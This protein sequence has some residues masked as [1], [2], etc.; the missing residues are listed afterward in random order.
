MRRRLRGRLATLLDPLVRTGRAGRE[1]PD[2]TFAVG[3]LRAAGLT[4]ADLRWL[5]ENHYL[6]LPLEATRAA[7]KQRLWRTRSKRSFSDKSNL[8]LTN[9]GYRAARLL[10]AEIPY[11]D[12]ELREL[13]VRGALVKVFTRPAPDQHTVLSTF[14]ELGWPRRIDDPL[15]FKR[16]RQNAKLRLRDTIKRLNQHQQRFLIRFHGNGNGEGIL[17]EFV[18]KPDG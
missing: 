1:A 15:H 12:L 14:E 8:V 16:G 9:A 10:L 7:E 5:L 6:R 4:T 17:W 3:A 11:Y 18:E 13:W 2:L